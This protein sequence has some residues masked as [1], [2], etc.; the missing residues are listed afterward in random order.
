MGVH[1]WRTDRDGAVTVT[2]D[3]RSLDVGAISGRDR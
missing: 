2:T 3:G 1:V